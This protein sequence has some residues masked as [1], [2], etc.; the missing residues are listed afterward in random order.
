VDGDASVK[1]GL[2]RAAMER[3]RRL[4]LRARAEQA[5]GVCA[6]L[7]AWDVWTEAR[8]VLL[9][10]SVGSEVATDAL[11]A[12]A[13]EAGKA[14]GVPVTAEGGLRTVE[15]APASAWRKGPHGIPEPEGASQWVGRWDVVV[16]PGLAFDRRGHR[17]GYG[18]AHYDRFLAEGRHRVSVGL[19]YRESV[20][21]DLPTEPHDV[22][23]DAVFTADGRIR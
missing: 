15:V 17:L 13:W 2:R 21:A 7:V 10:R 18:K 3:R 20:V 4:A 23:V 22:P 5:A 16:V 12:A 1:A 19:A 11:F 8:R 6:H 9:Y 14:V